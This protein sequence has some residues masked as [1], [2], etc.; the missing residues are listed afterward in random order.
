MKL[1]LSEGLRLVALGLA[2]GLAGAFA[3]TRS[4]SSLLYG[5]GAGD[6]L[7]FTGV[8]AVLALVALAAC[9]VP[10]LRAMRVDPMLALREE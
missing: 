7:T 5:V 2:I 4:L 6:P 9:A 1:I 8:A 3:L 10:A